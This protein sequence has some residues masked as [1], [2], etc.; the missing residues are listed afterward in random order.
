MDPLGCPVW[1][2]MH[3]VRSSHLVMAHVLSNHLFSQLSLA[4][5]KSVHVSACGRRLDASWDK[6]PSFNKLWNGP[7]NL[8]TCGRTTQEIRGH[9]RSCSRK[10]LS[11]WCP[12]L[13]KV[14]ELCAL[15]NVRILHSLRLSLYGSNCRNS[16][17]Y[18][19]LQ[20]KVFVFY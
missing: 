8:H 3:K 5:T 10:T 7:V 6:D 15:I 9:L 13:K 18:S 16:L 19:I 1:D 12:F 14:Y 20:D 11:L 4:N 2:C 17:I